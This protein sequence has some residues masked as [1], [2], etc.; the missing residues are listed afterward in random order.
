LTFETP[1][2]DKKTQILHAATVL[3]RDR[4]AQAFSFE[5]NAKEAGLSR[6]LVRYYYANMDG[7]IADLCDHLASTYRDILVAGIVDIG[8]VE[9][10][11][12]FLDFF[13]GLTESHPLPDNLEVYDAMVAFSVGSEPLRERMCAQY[14]TLGQV[15]IHELAIAHPELNSRACEE[16]SYLFVSMMHAHW[17][18]V[19]SLK[20][21]R[22]HSRLTRKA[23]DRLIA[24]Y[25]S[26]STP[27]KGLD[28][29]W[30][31]K[32]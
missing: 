4:G 5:N 15:I 26:D 12:F 22:E 16:L 13:F 19:A 30:A 32:P 24:S 17:S 27:T 9:R 3:L 6:Q 2:Q 25:V 11:S 7:F 10:L 18:F 28:R 29:A 31:Q 20:F 21:S 14:T 8:E 23:I 1:S